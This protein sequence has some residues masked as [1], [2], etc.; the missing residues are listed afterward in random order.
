QPASIAQL[1]LIIQSTCLNS[2]TSVHHSV[3]QS[4]LLAYISPVHH[5]VNQS[6][7]LTFDIK[8]N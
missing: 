1:L 7:L 2:S 3:N 6:L 8:R 5:S 4:L